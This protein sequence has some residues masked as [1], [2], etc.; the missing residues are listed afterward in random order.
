MD[1]NT[2][3][4]GDR[5]QAE[6]KYIRNNLPRHFLNWEAKPKTYKTYPNAKSIIQLPTPNFDDKLTF[7]EV[8]KNRKS[9]N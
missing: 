9:M 2:D 1:S 8:L 7:W 4:Y 3:N 6:S 5:F